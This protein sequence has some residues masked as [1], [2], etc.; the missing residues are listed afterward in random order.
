MSSLKYTYIAKFTFISAFI[1]TSSIVNGQDG[2]EVGMKKEASAQ[3]S[4][5]STSF[6]GQFNEVD[7]ESLSQNSF[8]ILDLL[9]GKDDYFGIENIKKYNKIWY[10]PPVVAGINL[11]HLS[12]T[13]YSISAIY[14][15]IA[16]GEVYSIIAGMSFI[17]SLWKCL[18]PITNM[19]TAI[20]HAFGDRINLNDPNLPKFVKSFGRGHQEHHDAPGRMLKANFSTLVMPGTFMTLPVDLLGIGL[21]RQFDNPIIPVLVGNMGLIAFG[22]ANHQVLHVFAHGRRNFGSK[23]ML[24]PF[25]HIQNALRKL[26][27]K[28]KFIDKEHHDKHHSGEHISNYSVIL[29]AGPEVDEFAT[30]TAEQLLATIRLF[31]MPVR[32]IMA[33]GNKAD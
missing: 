30:L 16:N 12:L 31:Y 24:N 8:S 2:M 21:L 5:V 13:L 7:K 18:L 26:Q 6:Q 1:L 28:R 3:Q 25:T 14:S 23:S 22:F 9:D 10:F 32:V 20:S 19:T 17:A 29:P 11:L 27:E 15:G 4:V 33:K